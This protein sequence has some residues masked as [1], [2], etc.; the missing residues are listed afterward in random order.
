MLEVIGMD[1][2]SKIEAGLRYLQA[3][4]DK[5]FISTAPLVCIR[6]DFI[7]FRCGARDRDIC[8]CIYVGTS[9]TRSLT[10]ENVKGI[11]LFYQNMTDKGVIIP[12]TD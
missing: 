10:P 1:D 3:F 4:P 11:I 2:L 8:I 6:C 5:E 9:F 12:S 7:A